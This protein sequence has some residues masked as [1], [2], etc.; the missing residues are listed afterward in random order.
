MPSNDPTTDEAQGT[1]RP[2]IQPSIGRRSV[3]KALGVGAALTVGSGV[4]SGT[5]T[6]SEVTDKDAKIHPLYGYSTPDAARIPA[7]LEPDYEV[8]LHVEQPENLQDPAHPTYF[9]FSPTGLQVE[10]GSVVQFTFKAPDHTVTA[11]HPGHGF[12]RRV[13]K[14]V[15]PFSAPIV[16]VQGAWLY[17]FTEPGIYDMYCGPHHILGMVMR[18]V[19]GEM[20]EEDVPAYE[21][22]F[23]GSEDPPLLPP[24]SKAFLE[25]ELNLFSD[26]NENAEWAWLTPREVLDAD[27]LDPMTVQREGSVSF[28]A[29]VASIDRF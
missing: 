21:D 13:P 19:V 1:E 25:R 3:M 23:E 20:A 18:L 11:Y 2:A 15:K 10:P 12:Q 28:D 22:T 4:G 16:N 29:V 5:E 6:T 27:A 7:A 9:H 26:Q 17:R 14:N 24:F 8:E